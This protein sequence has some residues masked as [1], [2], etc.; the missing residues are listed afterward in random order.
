[1]CHIFFMH[2]SVFGLLGCFHALA[3]VKRTMNIGMHVSFCLDIC[4]GVELLDNM[5]I[6]FL[7]F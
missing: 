6:L 3:I 1:M 4:P 5:V 7:V 2:S